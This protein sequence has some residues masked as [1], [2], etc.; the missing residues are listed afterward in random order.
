MAVSDTTTPATGD[1]EPFPTSGPLAQISI[2]CS[3]LDE[4]AGLINMCGCT[5]RREAVALERLKPEAPMQYLQVVAGHLEFLSD[6]LA[7]YAKE[8]DDFSDEAA[9]SAKRF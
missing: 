6:L 3:D 7:R 1:D 5:V 9:K 8:I 4:L 2:K